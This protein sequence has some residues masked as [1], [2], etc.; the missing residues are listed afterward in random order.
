MPGQIILIRLRGKIERMLNGMAAKTMMIEI[1][2]RSELP[3]VAEMILKLIEVRTLFLFVGEVGSGKTTLI[4]EIC[5]ALGI[6]EVAS[7]SF[8]IH[9]RYENKQGQSLDH[10]DLYRLTDEADLESTGFWDLF[11]QEKACVMVEW[12]DRIAE[13]AWP[14][15]WPTFKIEFEKLEGEKRRVRI[16]RL[17]IPK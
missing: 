14:I 15:N 11:Q 9:H 8:A 5:N 7:P 13:Q 6:D 2:Q 10:V 16:S 1:S 3:R 4:S 17:T 12:A